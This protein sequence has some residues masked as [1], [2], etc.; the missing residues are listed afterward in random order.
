MISEPCDFYYHDKIT[1]FN[2]NHICSGPSQWYLL[3]DSVKLPTDCPAN[4]NLW[5]NGK[6]KYQKVK[7]KCK[8]YYV[9]L[10][11]VIVTSTWL[12]SRQWKRITIL[13]NLT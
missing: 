4:D 7:F 5:I 2:V 3:D 10:Y 9:L 8:F 1:T 12:T 11:D 6:D 13:D